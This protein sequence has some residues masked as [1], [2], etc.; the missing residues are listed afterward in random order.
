RL[1]QSR[2][3]VIRIITDVQLTIFTSMLGVSLFL[4]V[5]LCRYMAIN[6]PKKQE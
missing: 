5:I 4:L 1:H 2:A 6:N 3:Q